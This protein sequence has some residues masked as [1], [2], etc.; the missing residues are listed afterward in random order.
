MTADGLTSYCGST[1][2]PPNYEAVKYIVDS[3]ASFIHRNV[4]NGDH[5]RNGN[6]TIC[7][8]C[9]CPDCHAKTNFNFSTDV[10]ECQCTGNINGYTTLYPDRNELGSDNYTTT[11]PETPPA[12]LWTN[13]NPG[14]DGCSWLDGNKCAGTSN[15]NNSAGDWTMDCAQA[16]FTCSTATSRFGHFL[17]TD[18]TNTIVDEELKPLLRLY[19]NPNHGIIHYHYFSTNTGNV[20]ILLKDGIGRTLN[21]YQ[22][23]MNEGKNTGFIACKNCTNGMI[24]I[25]WRDRANDLCIIRKL[26]INK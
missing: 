6:R 24:T 23:H 19:P 1:T 7:K 2:D 4:F 10:A 18:S 12:P 13:C 9:Y 8:P 21:A 15:E 26:L 17:I 3:S 22:F 16:A 20:D 11:C 5:T 25:E 14:A